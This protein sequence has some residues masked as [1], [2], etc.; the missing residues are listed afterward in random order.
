MA[1]LAPLKDK[2]FSVSTFG[3]AEIAGRKAVGVNVTREGHRPINLFFD[4]ETFRLVKS[5]TRVK[6]ETSGQEVTQESTFGEFKVVEGT[7]QPLKI[8]IK[9]DGK[10]HAD[11]EV[12]EF[13]LSESLDDSLFAK[14]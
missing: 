8:T 13:K 1:S 10:P 2:A 3:E 11:V 12:E 5:E 6:D 4:K 14:P 7:Q 9:R